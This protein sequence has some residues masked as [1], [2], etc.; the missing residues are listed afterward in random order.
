MR[1]RRTLDL[2]PPDPG[3][4]GKAAD[5]MDLI[6]PTFGC[7]LARASVGSTVLVLIVE[8]WLTTLNAA[9]IDRLRSS[10][11]IPSDLRAVLVSLANA[12][13]V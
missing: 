5:P 1:Y 9:K 3:V 4:D 2:D 13:G 12:A 11:P 8:S 6:S 7:A 10:S